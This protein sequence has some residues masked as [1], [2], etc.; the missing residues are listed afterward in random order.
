MNKQTV[1]KTVRRHHEAVTSTSHYVTL[2]VNNLRLMKQFYQGF[3]NCAL[4]GE[5]PSA[6]LLRAGVGSGTHIQM[7]G[8]LQRSVGPGPGRDAVNH[9]A[10]ILSAPERELERRR[11]EALG[12]R[13][14]EMNHNSGGK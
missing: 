1:S 6:A 9:I 3:L 11:L 14:Y 13:V 8:L 5:F 2:R 4:L 10:F 7:L 12:I